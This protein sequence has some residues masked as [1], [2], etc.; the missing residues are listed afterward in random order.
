MK[1]NYLSILLALS[2][3]PVLA[4]ADDN[5]KEGNSKAEGGSTPATT[6]SQA[7]TRG[8]AK[9]PAVDP[10]TPSGK[11]GVPQEVTKVPGTKFR[12]TITAADP[13]SKTITINDAE[14]GSHT[15]EVLDNTK[16]ITG[17][18]AVSWSDL[19]VGTQVEGVCRKDGEK[20][21]A[22]SLSLAK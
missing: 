15:I 5:I 13:A 11:Q 12:G 8:E 10:T 14:K 7:E 19:K 3:A 20:S 2:L 6:Q 18:E 17:S 21:V 16:G 9:S 1:S 22:D 4:L